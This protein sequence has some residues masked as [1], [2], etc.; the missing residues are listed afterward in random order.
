M[1]K[2][3]LKGGAF[4]EKQIQEPGSIDNGAYLLR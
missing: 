2:S 4:Y 3:N 1:S